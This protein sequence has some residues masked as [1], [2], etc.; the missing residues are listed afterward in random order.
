MEKAQVYAK[1][2]NARISPKKVAPVLDLIR[3]KDLN[4]AK[5]VLALDLTK[6]SNLITKVLRSVESNAKNN[7]NLKSENLY[8]SEATVDG[9]RTMKRGRIAARSRFSPI[10]KRTSHL[11]VGLS[12]KEPAKVV[13]ETPEK[14][15]AEKSEADKNADKEAG[16]NIKDE[17]NVK[18]KKNEKVKDGGKK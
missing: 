3:G 5:V 6:A 8:I 7:L 18:A 9:G 13:K 12:E 2:K 16:K 15:S 4:E 10:L 1:H 17:K 14:K 11:T